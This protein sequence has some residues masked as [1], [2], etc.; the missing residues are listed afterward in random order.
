MKKIKNICLTY[1]NWN[2]EH[3]RVNGPDLIKNCNLNE[4]HTPVFFPPIG[5]FQSHLNYYDGDDDRIFE[6][7]EKPL[8]EVTDDMVSFYAIETPSFNYSDMLCDCFQIPNQVINLTHSNKNFYLLF[9][10]EHESDDEATFLDFYRKLKNMGLNL[11]KVI[12]VTNNTKIYDIKKNNKLECI[13]YK[14]FFINFSSTKVLKQSRSEFISNKTGKFAMTRNKGDRWHRSA[15]IYEIFKNNLTDDINYSFLNVNK[16]LL[17]FDWYTHFYGNDNIEKVKK[18][19]DFINT[20]YKEC[21]YENGLNYINKKTGEF[22]HQHKFPSIFL[23]PETN[24]SFENSYLNIVTETWFLDNDKIHITEKSLRPFNFYQFPI[25]FATKGHVKALKDLYNFDMFDDIINHSYDD[26]E[27][28]IKRFNLIINEI[29]RIIQ[30]KDFFIK[31]YKN[32]KFRF[33]LNRE[34]LY[35]FSSS[36]ISKDIDFFWNL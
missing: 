26:E 3:P 24:A 5:W 9:L 27:D 17:D 34:K 15:L 20:H 31:F 11:N 10:R 12:F 2:Q 19:I 1:S 29:K 14:T 6:I 16:N 18:D 33:T 32:N 4:G 22:T 7:T 21:D 25:I 23:I 36:C 30:N 28:N 35:S 13:V 8:N